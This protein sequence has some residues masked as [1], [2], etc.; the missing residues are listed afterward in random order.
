M[1]TENELVGLWKRGMDFLRSQ[2]PQIDT[3][4]PEQAAAALRGEHVDVAPLTAEPYG[5][6]VW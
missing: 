4:T 5:V 6:F 3:L 2:A 1:R